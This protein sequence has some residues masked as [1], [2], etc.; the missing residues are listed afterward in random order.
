MG[1][2][3]FQPAS[4]DDEGLQSALQQTGSP[5]VQGLLPRTE[6]RQGYVKEMEERFRNSHL[7]QSCSFRFSG[8]LLALQ[9]RPKTTLGATKPAPGVPTHPAMERQPPILLP[10]IQ[11]SPSRCFKSLTSY[12]LSP[13]ASVCLLCKAPSQ[14]SRKNLTRRPVHT[15]ST[16]L[17]G[18]LQ[19]QEFHV[20]TTRLPV[21][22]YSSP[23]SCTA[24]HV[25][26]RL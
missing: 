14:C 3:P 26:T 4:C 21:S 1:K 19:K 25:T 8:N 7:C 9:L 11:T 2:D 5:S 18:Q 12:Y 15:T 16:A 17:E 22:H 6:T 10:N 13:M 23:S 20:R 24:R